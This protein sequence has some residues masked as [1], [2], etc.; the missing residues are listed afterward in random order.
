MTHTLDCLRQVTGVDREDRVSVDEQSGAELRTDVGW[1]RKVKKMIMCVEGGGD[2]KGK[3][4][5]G[6][7]SDCGSPR[8][9]RGLKA[10]LQA[11]QPEHS[12]MWSS[13]RGPGIHS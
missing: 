12:H 3:D 5:G 10:Q 4:P 9:T 2:S 1:R 13:S 7:K 6:S 8:V 11:G